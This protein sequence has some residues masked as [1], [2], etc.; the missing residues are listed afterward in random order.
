MSIKPYLYSAPAGLLKD[1]VIL[2]TGA[3][4][5][6]GQAAARCFAEHGATIILAGKTKSKLEAVYDSIVSADL[7]TPQIALIDFAK[8]EADDYLEI[9]TRVSEQFKRLDGL[10]HNASILGQLSPIEHHD[11]A[12][13]YEV[14]QVNLNSSFLL[15]QVLIPALKSSKEPSVIFTSSGVGRA[16]RAYWGAYAVSKFATEGLSQVLADELNQVKV[17][18][19]N[20]GATRTAMRKSAFPGEDPTKLLAPK[21]I[22][23]AYLFLMGSDSNGISGQSFDCQ[24]K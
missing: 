21:D 14:M 9:A 22:L 4:D 18:C 24:P 20:P 15:T 8:A 1:R 17:N 7:P 3:G 16:G 5:G 10:L 12:T 2:V 13:W 19:I 23:D 11:V 6:I